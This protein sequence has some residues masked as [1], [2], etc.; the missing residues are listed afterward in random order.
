MLWVAEDEPERLSPKA[1]KE[2]NQPVALTIR[3]IMS[4]DY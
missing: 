1:I 3:W 2:G 4:Y